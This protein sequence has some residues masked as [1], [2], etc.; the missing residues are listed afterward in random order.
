MSYVPCNIKI[1]GFREQLLD[2]NG[3]IEPISQAFISLYTAL[4]KT[5]IGLS[6]KV[7]INY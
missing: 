2:A 4:M 5:T 6:H 7:D 3:D 1:A